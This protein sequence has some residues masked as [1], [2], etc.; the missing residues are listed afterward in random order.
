MNFHRSKACLTAA[1]LAFAAFNVASNAR[2]AGAQTEWQTEVEQPK[3]PAA[4]KPTSTK[5]TT[6][7]AESKPAAAQQAPSTQPAATQQA[8]AQHTPQ[9]APAAQAPAPQQAPA[10]AQ[11]A[12]AAA[13]P[14]ANGAAQQTQQQAPAAV[15][16][17]DA[18]APAA[19]GAGA[20]APAPE[21]QAEPPQPA[22]PVPKPTPLPPEVATTIEKTTD[23]MDGAEKKLSAIKDVDADLG[24]LRN[25]IDGVISS[26]TRTADSL[27]PRLADLEGQIAKLGPAPGKDDP[28]EA[29]TAATERARLGAEAAE[30]SGAIKTLEVTWWRARQAIDKITDLR[31]ELFV[32]S[33]TQR[34]SS[35]L[36]SELWED[37]VR[38]W[39]SVSWRIGYNGSDW[40]RNA[41]TRKGRLSIVLAAAAFTYLFLKLLAGWLTRFRPTPGH[42]EWTF[43]ERA[44][45]GSWIA[46]V[47]AMPG[48]LTA[49][50]LYFGLDHIGLLYHP[51]TMPTATAL[52]YAILIFSAVSALV[53]TVFA[54]YSP[55]R[56]LIPLSDRAARRVGRLLKILAAIYCLDLFFSEF[57]QILYFPLSLSVVQSLISSLA[58]A[59]VLAGLLLTPFSP[60]GHPRS[61]PYPRSY[62]RWLKFPLWLVVL[63]IVVACLTGYV[64][65]GRFIAQQVVMTGIVALVG[66]LLF[67]AIRAFTREGTKGGHAVGSILHDAF[68]MDEPRRRQLAWLTEAVLTFILFLTLLPVLLLQWGFA[69]ADIRDWLKAALFG[70]EIGQI[71]IS[72]VR[73]LGGI[74]LFMALLFVTRLVQRR[75]RQNV[76]VAPRMDPGVANSVDTAVGY[77][78]IALASIIAV[79]YAGFDIT[80]LAIVAGALSVGIGFGLQ[81]IVNNFVSGLILLIERPIKVGDWV[82]VG[83]EEG[84]VKNISVRSTEI[85]TFNRASLI[86]PNSELITGRVMN[87]THRSALGRV[88]LRFSAGANADPRTVLAILQECA[89]AHPDVLSEPAPIA[90]FEGYTQTATEY[91]LRAFLG[92]ISSGVRVQSDLRVAVFEALREHQ[93]EKA[94]PLVTAVVSPGV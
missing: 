84:T 4:A 50:V 92:D 80:N 16:A 75:L 37:V 87:W 83:T 39:P 82:V 3:A 66:I 86:V 68:G 61:E 36:F 81:S 32:K 78:G 56:R 8:P 6:K 7:A 11:P 54:P 12:P 40:L 79:S 20:P 47:R 27:R 64:A 17:G 89:Q 91:S 14:A 93:I 29:P 88:V 35:P 48:I 19:E 77:T 49:L 33:L 21:T 46:P 76:L 74:L 85:E 10:A 57:A 25:D 94:M 2:T 55:Q 28:P 62:P 69:A 70:F 67:F 58:F 30:V 1:L 45:A 71:R 18:A 90:V 60:T 72:L 31:L 26:T 9:Q 15:P 13:A 24:R 73:I 51:T 52:L 22:K 34:M 44:A 41:D 65:L 43:F 5:A 42:P 23:V 53:S 59:A 63:A 38:D